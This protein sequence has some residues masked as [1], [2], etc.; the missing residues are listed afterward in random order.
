M[1]SLGRVN[2]EPLTKEE[3]ARCY[4]E[5]NEPD[6]RGDLG[7]LN[8]VIVAGDSVKFVDLVDVCHLALVVCMLDIFRIFRIRFSRLHD[9]NIW[10][11]CKKVLQG[12]NMNLLVYH[13]Q[14]KRNCA[15]LVSI[16]TSINIAGC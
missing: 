16:I 13:E 1:T 5:G 10:T 4:G 9:H 6:G 8:G 15:V 7:T 11:V 12:R 3:P 14:Y 2:K